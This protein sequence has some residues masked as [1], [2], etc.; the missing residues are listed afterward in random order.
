MLETIFILDCW[1]V[2]FAPFVL[3]AYITVEIHEC[4]TDS[5]EEIIEGIKL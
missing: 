3:I 4:I 5:W 1:L 2:F